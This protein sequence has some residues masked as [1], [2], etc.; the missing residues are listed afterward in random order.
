MGV[1]SQRR[2]IVDVEIPHSDRH[3]QAI[4]AI[5]AVILDQE[6]NRLDDSGIGGEGWC[7]LFPARRMLCSGQ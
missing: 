4:L 5:P 2:K 6:R 3:Q 1:R 7:C